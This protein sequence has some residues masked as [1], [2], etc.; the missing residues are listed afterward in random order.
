MHWLIVPL[1]SFLSLFQSQQTTYTRMVDHVSAS[2]VRV[3]HLEDVDTMQGR[4]QGAA[5]CTGEVIGRHRVLTAAHCLSTDYPLY[6][7]GMQAKVMASNTYDDLAL[8]DVPTDKPW[9]QVR[10]QPVQRFEPLTGIGYAFGWTRLTVL[11]VRVIF[12]NMRV[13]EDAAPGILVQPGYIGGM[14]GGP[15][16]DESGL[17]VGVVQRAAE[18]VGYGVGVKVIQAFLLNEDAD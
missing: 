11:Q 4:M 9:L 8:L 10:D 13:I 18:G 16:V 3:T 5:V 15:V 1:L 14:S 7:D 17:M 12:P 2:V 6:V